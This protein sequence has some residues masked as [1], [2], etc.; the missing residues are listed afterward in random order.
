M[1]SISIREGAD[2]RRHILVP[3]GGAGGQHGCAIA[4]RLGIETILV[5]SDAGVLS[6]IGLAHARE[7]RFAERTLNRTFHCE[8]L[9]LP[10][11]I[12]HGA[13]CGY[14]RPTLTNG[15]D[16]FQNIVFIETR[17]IFKVY[18]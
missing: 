6:A 10:S 4:E 3:F 12:D 5:P 18:L 8:E 16:L 14:M 17:W 9:T 13:R 2:P 7:E 15:T 1:R 11:K